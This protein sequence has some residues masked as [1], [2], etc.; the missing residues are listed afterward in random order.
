MKVKMPAVAVVKE[1]R[2]DTCELYIARHKEDNKVYTV[3]LARENEVLFI[4]EDSI[5]HGTLDYFYDEYTVVRKYNEGE[6]LSITV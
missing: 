6:T 5:C 4:D 3:I 2:L 1:Q